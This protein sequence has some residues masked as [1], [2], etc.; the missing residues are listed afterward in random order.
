MPDPNACILH[1][2]NQSGVFMVVMVWNICAVCEV[3]TDLL[4]AQLKG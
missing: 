2:P 1:V 4:G 3:R